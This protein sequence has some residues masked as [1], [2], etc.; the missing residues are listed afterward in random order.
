L[1]FGADRGRTRSGQAQISGT[2]EKV[3]FQLLAEDGVK[4]TRDDWETCLNK[5]L[6]RFAKWRT[7]H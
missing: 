5:T 2:F 7:W 3:L 1:S 6:E 4:P